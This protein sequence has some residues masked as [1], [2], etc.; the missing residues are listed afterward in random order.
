MDARIRNWDHIYVLA[1]KKP[2]QGSM[3]WV[4]EG[5]PKRPVRSLGLRSGGSRAETTVT[6][7]GGRRLLHVA[8]GEVFRTP[9][10]FWL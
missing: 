4:G 10:P 6:R 2:F 3:E 1:K 7:R 9:P 5:R 8:P